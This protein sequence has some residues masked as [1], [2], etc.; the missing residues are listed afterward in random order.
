MQDTA[1]IT[2]IVTIINFAVALLLTACHGVETPHA[3]APFSF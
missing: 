3:G 2:I 1:A